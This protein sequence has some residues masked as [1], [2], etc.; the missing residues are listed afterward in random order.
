MTRV[1]GNYKCIDLCRDGSIV[2][3]LYFL[4]LS[5]LSENISITLRKVHNLPLKV[6]KITPQ[7]TLEN[8]LA[9]QLKKQIALQCYSPFLP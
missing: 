8:N 9:R 7:I 1:L 4:R 2:S 5:L 3:Y 6:P